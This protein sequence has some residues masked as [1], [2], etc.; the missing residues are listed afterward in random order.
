MEYRH[1]YPPLKGIG[2]TEMDALTAFHR[3][4]PP[5]HKIQLQGLHDYENGYQM[6][7]HDYVRDN[8]KMLV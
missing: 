2:A 4:L 1:R 6:G 7:Q 5:L 8:S 3:K